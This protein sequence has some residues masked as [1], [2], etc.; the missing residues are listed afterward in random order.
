MKISSNNG[1]L[2]KMVLAAGTTTITN[3]KQINIAILT[4][5]HFFYTIL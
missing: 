2:D 1:A 5:V 3:A 4:Y